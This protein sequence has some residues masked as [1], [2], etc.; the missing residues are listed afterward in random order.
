M[1][2]LVTGGAGFIGFHLTKDIVT[3]DEFEVIFIDN[4]NEYYSVQLKLDRLRFLGIEISEGGEY[5]IPIKS[6]LYRNLTFYK[7]DITDENNLEKLF[8][9]YHFSVVVNLAAQAGVRYSID[10]PR[11]YLSS[12]INGFF[13]V[14][15]FSKKYHVDHL[16]FA[17][18]SSVYGRN[19][20]TPYSESD[21]TDYPFSIY[22][23]T[24]K[25]NE[26]MGHV[27]SEMYGMKITALRFF[28]V[29]GPWGRPD[30]LYFMAVKNILENKPIM[31][32]NNGNMKRDFTYI[33]DIIS[34]IRLMIEEFDK[35]RIRLF[36]VYNLGNSN[37][38]K[39]LD[40]IRLLEDVTGKKAI[41]EFTG[42]QSG[43]VLETFADVR[44]M[45]GDYGFKPTTDLKGGIKEFYN[46]YCEYYGI[47]GGEVH[48]V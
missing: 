44:K 27:Y 30:M 34:G 32:F 21:N 14:L 36:E 12:N 3:N 7:I 20:R 37:S 43:D 39:L 15:D 31:I 46:W 35:S 26:L 4:I 10:N 1:K 45:N 2:I 16:I 18:S 28:T 22:A 47:N 33:D 6:K 48:G 42:M 41:L 25:S 9:K 19:E 17:S 40:F 24:K 11:A 8:Q 38:Q 29:F 5:G 23:A 13:N